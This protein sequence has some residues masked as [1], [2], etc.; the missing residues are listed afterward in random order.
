MKREE[1]VVIDKDFLPKLGDVLWNNHHPLITIQSIY[2]LDK[3]SLRVNKK[4]N[5][6]VTKHEWLMKVI[7]RKEAIWSQHKNDL[8]FFPEKNVNN[9]TINR[10]NITYM[11]Y[12]FHNDTKQYDRLYRSRYFVMPPRKERVLIGQKTI[13]RV[14]HG[15]C[16]FRHPLSFNVN[17][18]MV[19]QSVSCGYYGGTYATPLSFLISQQ[20]K[21]L[22][23]IYEDYGIT[24]YDEN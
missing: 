23:N 15:L 2:S 9:I 10:D 4:Y 19:P 12:C 16:K 18:I 7:A 17:G 1:S 20:F 6:Q 14:S 8:S 24:I 5:L 21:Y 13:V 11:G 3:R 22:G